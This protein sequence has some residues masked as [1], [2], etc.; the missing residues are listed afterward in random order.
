MEVRQAANSTGRPTSLP[1][2]HSSRRGTIERSNGDSRVRRATGCGRYS[3]A[4]SAI[5]AP[6]SLAQ[7][8]P[9]LVRRRLVR[10]ARAL[11][12]ADIRTRE[13]PCALS[14]FFTK[15]GS[16]TGP[17]TSNPSLEETLLM[18]TRPLLTVT[19]LLAA[20]TMPDGSPVAPETHAS[21][22]IAVLSSV[23]ASSRAPVIWSSTH[24]PRDLGSKSQGCSSAFRRG[25]HRCDNTQELG[26]NEFAG[27]E[28]YFVGVWEHPPGS[29]N[30]R[31]GITLLGSPPENV[32]D[33]LTFHYVPQVGE[34]LSTPMRD[35][36]GRGGDVAHDGPA[37]DVLPAM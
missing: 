8:R 32:F 34:A 28:I 1:G 29:D 37:F 13:P 11:F 18:M 10:S 21:A 24:H 30:V 36:C 2:C 9:P 23:I 35:A 7:H 25:D 26:N 12:P 19:L 14:R 4:R 27:L 16:S 6:R 5:T 3:G 15:P 33:D 20:C 31:L 22:E 17:A